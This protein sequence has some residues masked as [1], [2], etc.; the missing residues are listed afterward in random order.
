[1]CLLGDF[2]T[3]GPVKLVS[4]YDGDTFVCTIPQ[5]PPII[6]VKIR[7]RLSGINAPELN[8]KDPVERDL[9]LKAKNRL[10]ELLQGEIYLDKQ[11]RD[12]YFRIDAQV[13]VNG[14]NVNEL[15]LKEGFVKKYTYQQLQLNL[16]EFV[17]N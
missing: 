11:E 9:A 17:R 3:V 1:M 15:M 12:R 5:Y 13:R 16:F 6:G 10:K 14:V 4:V 2:G 7:V 8:S